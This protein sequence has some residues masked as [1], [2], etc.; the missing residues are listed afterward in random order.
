MIKKIAKETMLPEELVKTL[1][2]VRDKLNSAGIN[3][4][5]GGGVA[6]GAHSRARTTEDI[7]IIVSIKD[8]DKI[9]SM[10]KTEQL[11]MDI[12]DGLTTKVNNIDIDFIFSESK[13]DFFFND[14]HEYPTQSNINVLSVYNLIYMKILSKRSKDM[15]DVI[16]MLKKLTKEQRDEGLKYILKMIKSSNRDKNEKSDLI[17]NI[18]EEYT[19][20]SHI[21]ELENLRDKRASKKFLDAI[22]TKNGK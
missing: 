9:Q 6:V 8:K 11:S 13:E 12:W 15:N 5:V 3:Y 22:V 18:N 1:L 19:S 14:K 2:E 17:E 20:L 7:D 4:R 10:F 21:A 16:Q